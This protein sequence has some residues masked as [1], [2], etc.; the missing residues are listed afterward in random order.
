[1]D[2]QLIAY[3]GLAM[4]GI[5]AQYTAS[6]SGLGLTIT[7]P[8]SRTADGGTPREVTIPIGYAGTLTTRTDDNTGTITLSGGHA[9]TTGANVDIYWSGGVQ[10]DVTVGT[11]ATNS[12][13]FDSGIGNNLPIATTAVVVAVRQQINVDL[14]GDNA[15]LVA[16]KQHYAQSSETAMSHVDFQDSASDEIAEIDLTANVPQVWDI[17][18]GSSNPFTGDPITKCFVSNG[19]ITNAATF[20]LI[21]LVDS[22]P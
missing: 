6:V 16:I 17:A 15:Q 8:I 18:G 5:V 12:M 9:I 7:Q 20:Q 4:V 3:L 2:W 14:D 1:M 11:V 21:A 10:Y 13:P 22:T 19:S